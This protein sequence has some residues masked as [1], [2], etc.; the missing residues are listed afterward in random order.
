MSEFLNLLLFFGVFFLMV[1]IG[2]RT[3]RPTDHGR[4]QTDTRRAA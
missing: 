2:C 4:N 3:D 1:W